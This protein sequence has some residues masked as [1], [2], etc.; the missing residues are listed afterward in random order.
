MS[1]I[2]LIHTCNV[3]IYL[4]LQGEDDRGRPSWCLSE[5]YALRGRGGEQDE[6]VVRICLL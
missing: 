1:K 2:Q 4:P 5:I 6:S 3:L